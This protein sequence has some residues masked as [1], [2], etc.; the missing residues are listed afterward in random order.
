MIKIDKVIVVEGKYDK[1]KLSSLIDGTIVTTG[2]FDIFTNKKKQEMLRTLARKTGIIILTDS[3][4]A[5]FRIRRFISGIIKDGT[6]LHAYIP[7]VYGKESRKDKPSK[8]GKL[9]VEGIP[10]DVI[11]KALADAGAFCG[12]IEETEDKI[13][14]Q[15]FYLYGLTGSENSAIKREKLL[16][17]LGLPEHM[18][19]N[20]L[21]KV[22]G[23]IM[24]RDEFL[25][26]VEKI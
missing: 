23:N 2:G 1:I 15:D 18:T 11:E 26:L 14:K 6:V 22:I 5:G 24:T 13:T 7:D 4:V 3:D 17:E 12:K 9:G 8:E 21:I 10:I 25:S 19:T 16:S 20:S